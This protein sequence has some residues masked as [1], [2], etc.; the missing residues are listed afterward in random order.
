MG[1]KAQ[2]DQDLKQA[3]LSGDKIKATTLRGLKSVILNEE[4]AR[5]VRDSG[6]NEE[7]VITCLKKEA[8]KRQEAVA[9]YEQAGS[10]ERAQQE[11]A[12]KQIIEAYLP[13]AL[14]EEEIVKLVDS[15]IAKQ[16]ELTP[17]SMGIIIGEVKKTAGPAADGAVI[18]RIVKEKLQARG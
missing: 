14:P 8:K 10:V 12:E 18:A 7:G 6:L 4:I 11:Q 9:L 5:G 3:L 17:A 16:T 15:A 13:T 1:L 2:I